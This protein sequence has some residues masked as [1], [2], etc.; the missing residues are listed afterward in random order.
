MK[1]PANKFRN[2]TKLSE[3]TLTDVAI[4]PSLWDRIS[5]FSQELNP[6][7]INQILLGAE[8]GDLSYLYDLYL[9]IMTLDTRIAGM[10]ATR[11]LAVAGKDYA[12]TVKNTDN[13]QSSQ[14]GEELRRMFDRLK[15]HRIRKQMMDGAFMGMSFFEN[16]WQ[17]EGD[18]VVLKELRQVS[19]SRLGFEYSFGSSFG[20][21]YI[22]LGGLSYQVPVSEFPEYKLTKCIYEDK[23]GYYDLT[24]ILRSVIRW[25][26]VKYYAV[27]FWTMFSETYGMP[28]QVIKLQENRYEKDKH[29]AKKMMK[30]MGLSKYT[31]L[32]DN[33]DYELKEPA[34]N[35]TVDTY[36]R[37]I[38]LANKEIAISIL[39]QTLTSD[40]GGSG[41]RA[42]GD[43]HQSVFDMLIDFDTAWLDEVINDDIVT[44]YMKLNYPAMDE[45]DY[46]Y[47]HSITTTEDSEAGRKMQ[48]MATGIKTAQSIKGLRIPKQWAL[49]QLGIPEADEDDD[50]LPETGNSL[51]DTF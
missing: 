10:V 14:A 17:Q 50:I 30:L 38:D 20:E 13:P 42:L 49:E 28:I 46:P 37:L 16:I 31:I 41:S 39:G 19:Q 33:M 9:K 23:A 44:P 2:S 1:Y 29:E 8:S 24:G 48:S 26:V 34:R 43:V 25:Y 51:I 35:S 3:K 5:V 21:P 45:A 22:K 15:M 18:K 7:A 11:K 47:Y 6:Q 36:E 40:V 32:F 12:V 27:K 4:E